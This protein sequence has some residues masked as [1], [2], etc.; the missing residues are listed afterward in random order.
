M[1]STAQECRSDPP[2]RTR[3]AV[4]G[5]TATPDVAR[6]TGI[7]VARHRAG[8]LVYG[9]TTASLAGI[10][11]A[12][13]LG[14]SD[15]TLGPTYLLPVFASIFL[16]ATTI[17]PGRFNVW[18]TVVAAQD[19]ADRAAEEGRLKELEPLVDPKHGAST[20]LVE[21]NTPPGLHKIVPDIVSRIDS[22]FLEVAYT[23]WTESDAGDKKARK[24]LRAAL[25][26]L[27]LPVTGELFN[28]PMVKK[29]LADSSTEGSTPIPVSSIKDDMPVSARFRRQSLLRSSQ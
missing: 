25:K 14:S 17:T 2:W 20:Q 11:L 21:E 28:K 13:T 9:S 4:P 22:I 19:A 7:N 3:H 5:T 10:L 23:G 15:P 24:E 26:N 29:I 8:A 27:G 18:G 16:G 12:G 6:L 1:S